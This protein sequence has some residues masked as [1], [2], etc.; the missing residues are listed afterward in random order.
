MHNAISKKKAI[1]ARKSRIPV[2]IVTA[3]PAR[4]GLFLCPRYAMLFS[5]L[6]SRENGKG[7]FL[8]LARKLGRRKKK[9]KKKKR[10]MLVTRVPCWRWDQRQ[11][12][13]GLGK[14]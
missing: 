14:G 8:V 2:K 7:F 3:I 12:Q 6:R 13:G 11:G 1:K 9:R 4:D 5:S 10:S